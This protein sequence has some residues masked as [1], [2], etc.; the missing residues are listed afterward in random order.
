M[1]KKCG[2]VLHFENIAGMLIRRNGIVCARCPT[3]GART[4]HKRPRPGQRCA[5]ESRP[6]SFADSLAKASAVDMIVSIQ[7]AEPRR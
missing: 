4:E 3:C 5:A 7:D 6:S 2:A 1:K